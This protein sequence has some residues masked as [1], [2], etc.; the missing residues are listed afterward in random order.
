M[1]SIEID[2]SFPI[3]QWLTDVFAEYEKQ[4]AEKDKQDKPNE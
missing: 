1:P 4:E 2:D 3:P